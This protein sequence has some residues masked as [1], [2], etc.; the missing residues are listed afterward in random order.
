MQYRVYVYVLMQYELLR[1][2]CYSLDIICQ[3]CVYSV[4]MTDTKKIGEGSQP[5]TNRRQEKFCQLYVTSPFGLHTIYRDADYKVKDDEDAR[6]NAF[7]LLRMDRVR[8]RVKYLNNKRNVRL[9]LDGDNVIRGLYEARD[10]CVG[11]VIVRDRRGNP[12]TEMVDIGSGRTEMHVVYRIDVAG[13]TRI[14][15]IL[16]K[17]HGLLTDKVEVND[18]RVVMDRLEA[19]ADDILATLQQGNAM[20]RDISKVD[21]SKKIIGSYP[22]DEQGK[23]DTTPLE[24]PRVMAE[25]VPSA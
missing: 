8:L 25:D 7:R 22:I 19:Q 23:V 21:T 14:S 4:I 1:I 13:F 10:K 12:I 6:S 2:R 24:S 3:I 16:A 15:E 9:G 11:G 18:N 5:L 17:Y 20:R